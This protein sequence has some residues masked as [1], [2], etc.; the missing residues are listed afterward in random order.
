MPLGQEVMTDYRTAGLSL[1]RHPVALIRDQLKEVRVY[2]AAHEGGKDTNFQYPTSNL[3][4]GE[5][6]AGHTLDLNAM[7]GPDYKNYRWKVYKLVVT[8]RNINY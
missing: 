8:P 6:S 1:K 4:V 7:V 2:I 5:Y 3:V